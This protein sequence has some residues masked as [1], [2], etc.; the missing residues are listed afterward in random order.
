MYSKT[1]LKFKYLDHTVILGKLNSQGG[2]PNQIY[3]SSSWKICHQLK[4]TK[5]KY[6]EE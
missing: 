2:Y 6:E 3:P 4:T 1:I 5:V